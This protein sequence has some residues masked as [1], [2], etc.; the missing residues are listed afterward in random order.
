MNDANNPTPSP[1]DLRSE[2][3]PVELVTMKWKCLSCRA[4]FDGPTDH[5]PKRGCPKCGSHIIFDINVKPLG[6]N[7]PRLS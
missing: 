7:N 5:A 4:V 3:V 1:Q 2:F 6:R